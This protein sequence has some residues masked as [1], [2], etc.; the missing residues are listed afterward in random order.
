MSRDIPQ[1]KARI[2]DLYGAFV[3]RVGGWIAV[4]DLISLLGEFGTDE[5]A[6]RSA[7]SRM[8]AKALLI[9]E[10][11]G[12]SA[13]YRL[14]DT[15]AEILADGD[16]RIF[17]TTEKKRSG[18]VLC[19][20][21]VPESERSQRYLIRSRLG[22]LGFGQAA[23]GVWIA[24]RALRPEAEHML[25]RLDV[26]HHVDIWEGAYHGFGDEKE[27]VASAWDLDLLRK[28]YDEYLHEYGDTLKG[29]DPD[30]DDADRRAFVEYLESL[31]HW[32]RLPYLDPGLPR[33]LTPD[34]WPAEEAHALFSEI[35]RQLG[36]RAFEYFK[37]R[38]R[39]R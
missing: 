2:L 23:P 7:C 13:G 20:F 29:W 35:D 27:L 15:G 11:R 36:G 19:V 37:T 5:N 3:R 24:P 14:S 8:K 6:V 39:S 4:A 22:W 26:A 1:P 30:T 21:S 32:R 18:W 16:L 33:Q 28:L 38:V 17:R 31:A 25:Q 9:A 10:R 12:P 34:D